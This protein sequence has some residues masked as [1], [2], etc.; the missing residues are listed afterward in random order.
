VS[1]E[2]GQASVEWVGLVLMVALVLG[3]VLARGTHVDGRS[4]GGFLAHRFACAVE[5]GRCDDGDPELAS[6]YGSE[7]ADLVRRHAPNIAY[8]PGERELPVD[9]RRCRSTRCSNAPLD[10]D[11]DVH[12]THTGEQATVYTRVVRRGGRVYI[13]YWL[14]YPDSN[15]VLMGSDKAW[16]R[17]VLLPAMRSLIAGDRRY[18]GFHGDDW[19]GYQVR[20]DPDGTVWARAT[21]HGGYQGCKQRICHNRW[22]GSTG[23]T[24]VSRGSHAGHVPLDLRW[25]APGHEREAPRLSPR[26]PGRDMRERSSTGEGLRLVP[27]EPLRGKRRYRPLAKEVKPPW[28]KPAYRHPETDSS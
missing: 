24:R 5:A 2:S 21:A 16:E 6:A 13:Q 22:V 1:D 11:A 28:E 18:P 12:R 27:L 3:A 8:E 14:Y 26:Y 10:R 4:F 7:D 17:S 19:E 15:T 23:W 9:F 25:R 20:V